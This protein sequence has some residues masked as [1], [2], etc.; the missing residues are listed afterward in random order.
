M[1]TMSTAGIQLRL[2]RELFDPAGE[3]L[4]AMVLCLGAA[5]G[6]GDGKGQGRAGAK[7]SGARRDVYLCLLNQVQDSQFH[8]SI[9][10]LRGAAAATD[11]GGGATASA[12]TLELP[13]KKRTWSLKELTALDAGGDGRG[14]ELEFEK[15]AS[16]GW[17]AVAADDKKRFLSTLINLSARHDRRSKKKLALA[18]LPA[19]VIVVDADEGAKKGPSDRAALAAKEAE[20]AE[21]AYE[22]ISSKEASDL[23][24][25]MGK[26]DHA[27][28]NADVF[29]DDLQRELS[30]LD[31]ANIHSI[32][33][34]EESVAALMEL[35]ERA[36]E[37]TEAVEMRLNQ[38]DELLERIRDSMDKMEGK[39]VSIETVNLN[40]KKL[41]ESLEKLLKQLDVPYKQ[42][43]A[44]A[45]ADLSSSRKLRE[46]GQAARALQRVL[47]AEV[48]ENLARMTAVQDQIK[49][50]EKLRDRFSKAVSRHLSNLF[51]HLGNDTM[52]LDAGGQQLKL[53]RRKH[54][55][56]ELLKYSDLVHWLKDMDPKAF[57]A[58]Q[59]L[60]RENLCKLYDKD[61]K[62]FFEAA[63]FR[64]SGDRALQPVSGSSYD[65]S[66]GKRT[67]GG[68]ST[69]GGAGGLLTPGTPGHQQ[70]L[71][72][73][74]ADSVSSADLS[75]SER[76]RFDDVL[77]TVL[78]EL[79]DVCMD[80]QYF[81]IHFF[82]ME[83]VEAMMGKAAAASASSDPA[84]A[85][86]N[87][88]AMEEAR[89]MMAEIFPSLES[90]LLQF[91]SFYERTD[92]FFTLHALVRLSR[93]VLS[94]QDTGS[95]LAISFGTVLVQIKRNFDRFMQAQQRSV[96]EARPPTRGGGRKGGKC[97]VLPFVSN[98][99]AFIAT[100]EAIFRSSERRS[101]L[102]K[103]YAALVAESSR[104]IGRIAREHGR[105]PAEVVKME[106]FHHLHAVLAQAKVPAL[107]A[108]K[109]ELKQRYNESL[110]S[111]VTQYFG[112]PLVKLNQ[113]FEGVQQLVQAGVKESEVGYQL[114][115]SKQELRKVISLYP[116]KEVKKGLESLYKKVERH[117]CEE[118]GL[119]QVVWRAMQ[120]E[121]I[122]QYKNIEDLI[123]R[124]YPG[125]QIALEFTINEVLEYFSDIARSH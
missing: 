108:H 94:T 28:T 48:D 16:H 124:C 34:S 18:N 10:E 39:T 47:T 107:D 23:T 14:F 84:A 87:K 57:S 111:Y 70:Q 64:V 113:F 49:R 43:T 95:F 9:A 8:I 44:L 121:F 30:V 4:L 103:W 68:G 66:G 37:H 80:E 109:K 100:S 22:P 56:K 25:L 50:C 46:C 112:R 58:L 106:N 119:T 59:G 7:T 89:A 77:E 88:K 74:D 5:A 35:L 105:T 110:R 12:Q 33:A 99:E 69:I 31:G 29:L 92:A 91:V 26:C 118:E 96:E 79:E 76:E 71:L 21:E 115:Y 83:R 52:N 6:G 36:V 17:T 93:H 41:L 67:G 3:Q 73:T 122:S 116:G 72:G 81:S 98:L 40:N 117:L 102:E 114:A 63:R 78:A 65:L 90:E 13:K 27:V 86:E 125:A 38:Y 120:E 104:S 55:H 60:Y 11:G 20:E 15:G 53:S 54:I 45:E 19:D 61:I 24:A 97:G 101:D 123:Q 62:K 1:G 85:R 42:Q 32:M 82:R 51:V 2:Q 75:L